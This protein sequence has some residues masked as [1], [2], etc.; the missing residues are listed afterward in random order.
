[1]TFSTNGPDTIIDDLRR[2]KTFLGSP[3]TV[4]L[5]DTTRKSL[6][7]WVAAGRLPAYKIGKNWKFDP[8]DLIR[9]LDQRRVGV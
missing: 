3:E 2:R 4:A 7:E 6:G 9:F 5:L 8:A 1:M